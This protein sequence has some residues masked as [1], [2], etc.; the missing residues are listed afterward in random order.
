LK[1][2]AAI[3]RE[4]AIAGAIARRWILNRWESPFSNQPGTAGAALARAAGIL[5]AKS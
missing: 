5:F 2:I 1:K 3:E 4:I